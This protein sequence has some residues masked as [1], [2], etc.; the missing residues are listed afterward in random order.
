VHP[1]TVCGW[2]A[3]GCPGPNEAGFYDLA[4]IEL[5]LADRAVQRLDTDE[6]GPDYA[7]LVRA[8]ADEREHLAAIA[9]LERRELEAQYVPVAWVRA[10]AELQG[11]IVRRELSALVDRL[12]P[13]LVGVDEATARAIFKDEA[14]KTLNLIAGAEG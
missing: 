11:V 3:R 8:R 4:A 7:E 5:W 2:L 1:S 12:A 13:R 14:R 10:R 9:E 6:L